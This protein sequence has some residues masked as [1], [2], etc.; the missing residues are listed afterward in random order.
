MGLSFHD[1]PSLLEAV[2]GLQFAADHPN[3]IVG[4][5]SFDEDGDLGIELDDLNANFEMVQ[6]RRDNDDR[7]EEIQMVD[8]STTSI[9][10]KDSRLH[11]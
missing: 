10:F 1:E 9:E 7:S 4:M 8:R 11:Q 3:P 6:E 5:G 2:S